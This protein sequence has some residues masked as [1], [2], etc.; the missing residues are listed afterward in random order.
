VAP[1]VS[2]IVATCDR[3]RLLAEA[4]D[5][6]ARQTFEDWECLVADDGSR[7]D[8]LRVLDQARARDFRIRAI[9][10]PH[11][12]LLG[13]VRNRAISEATGSLLALLDD[14]DIWLP[15]KLA[16]QVALLDAEPD[17][18]LAFARA[19]RFGEATGAFPKAGTPSRPSFER[20][21]KRNFIPCSTV[22]VRRRALQLAGGFDE[23]L[24]V[25]QDYDLWLRIARS[26]PIRFQAEVL[27]R[28]RVHAGAMSA[29]RRSEAEALEAIYERLAERWRLPERFSRLGHRH[30]RR[31]RRRNAVS[32]AS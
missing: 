17:V 7:D 13:R 29:D 19:E 15:G 31:F 22:I 25:A 10:G 9:P 24:P 8:T 32:R 12:G 16:S 27:C 11:C 21:W 20:L 26:Y 18:A 23:S 5:S 2:V 14:D 1:R 6:V 28:Y 3:S 4:L 30:V